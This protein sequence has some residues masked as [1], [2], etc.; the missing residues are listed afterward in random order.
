M[1]S[2]MMFDLKYAWRLFLKTPANS[3]LCIIVV[4]LSVGLS[5]FV[6]VIDYNMFL[7]PLPF[8][9]SQRWLSLQIAEN[10]SKSHRPNIDAYT[11]QE[12]L[13]RSDSVDY[14]GAFSRQP[15][16][17]S[18]GQAS[19]RL[20]A[21]AVSPELLTATKVKPK[22]GR[23]FSPADSQIGAA[24]T[25][26]LSFSTWQTYF[27]ADPAIIG[28][29][30]RIDGEPVQVIGVLPEDFFAFRDFE[31]WLPL[32]LPN[33]ANP[34]DSTVT[35]SPVVIL[36]EGQAADAALKSMQAVV[37]DINKTHK[38]LFSPERNLDLFP[39]NRMYTHEN[40]AVVA[41]AT[42]IAVAVLLLGG[43]NISLIIFAMLL[44]RA[45]EL[46]LRTALGSTRKRLIR[47]CLLQ[48]AFVVLFG[49][50]VGCLLAAMAVD[51]AHGLL[52][53]TAR[54]QAAGRDPNELVIRP[55]DLLTAIAVAI[56]LWLASTLIPA[57]RISRL[58]PALTL[59]GS[60]KGGI[61]TRGGNKTASILVG[62]QVFVSSLLL[63]IC[64]NVVLAVNKELS[65]PIGVESTQRMI[66]T[67]PTIFDSRYADPNERLL[68]W[69][70][71]AST[72]KER[73]PGAEVAFATASPTSPDEV[74]AII[75]DRTDVAQNGTMTL[76]VAAVSEGYFALLGIKLKSGRLFDNTDDRSSVNVAVVDERTAERYWPGR[77]PIGQR[78]RF[79]PNEDGPWL[80]V[81]GVVTA[82]SEPYPA[83]AGV[84][85]Q[86]LRQ[87]A[88]DAFHLLVQ[89]PASASNSREALHAAAFSV[90][91]NLP[92]HNLQMLD[93]Y[94]V[95]I[96]SYKSL[97]PGFSGIGL[98]LITLA[99]TGL[100]GLIGRSVAQRTQ[101]IGILRALG[102]TKRK[103][104]AKF[105]RQ[106]LIYLGVALVGGCV[107]VAMTTS[108][109]GT[110]SNVLD[111]VVPVT[112]G[113]FALIALVIFASSFVPTRRAISM[114]PGDALRYE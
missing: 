50:V 92:L 83:T 93:D 11:Y 108:M 97:V 87:A 107:G 2:N 71:L 109:S 68:Y 80:E 62:L 66:S 45:R 40:I 51:W 52:D 79:N 26:V 16:L 78:V 58:D 86:P 31:I 55:F 37:A 57:W 32:Q 21:A 22:S 30:T 41:M 56:F 81:V 19:T 74:P 63:V 94:L 61:A 36:K 99:A 46:A 10:E 8:S 25:A 59:A 28:K 106:A 98:V 17:L 112:A 3:L 15:A 18:E 49:L 114:E 104:T 90:N 82:V 9:D 4:A 72:I 35:L 33:L 75:A 60:G 20:R 43:L 27:A 14:L 89:L 110:I 95:A 69:D 47:Q 73:V 113:V 76:P 48:S 53:F 111:N 34:G 100:F 102:C 44:E 65:K 70:Q 88:P 103:V 39:A 24:R 67:Y 1:L 64:A 6:Y 42:F 84:I 101:E 29:Q 13:K 105:L 7:K 38:S 85:Y 54:I 77:S 96:N 23:I 91:P 12:L 5:L